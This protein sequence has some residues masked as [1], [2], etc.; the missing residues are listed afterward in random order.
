M[1]QTHRAPVARR[2]RR[3][4][5]ADPPPEETRGT[6][7]AAREAPGLHPIAT[8]VARIVARI[9]RLRDTPQPQPNQPRK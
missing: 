5:P 6:T 4:R 7:P 3:D 1:A 8:V 2:Q 9:T